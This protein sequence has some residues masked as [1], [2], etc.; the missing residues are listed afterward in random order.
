MSSEARASD[1]VHPTP[2]EDS[3][4]V[5]LTDLAGNTGQIVTNCIEQIAAEVILAHALPS[6]M[7]VV[8]EEGRARDEAATARPTT[9]SRSQS[10]IQSRYFGL[11]CGVLS[12]GAPPGRRWIRLPWKPCWERP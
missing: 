5:I 1:Y 3:R 12:S 6:S 10:E 8:V 9:S 11:V 4:V 7:T 2:H